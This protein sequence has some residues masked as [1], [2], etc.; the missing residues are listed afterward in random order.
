M[1][2]V[3]YVDDSTLEDVLTAEFAD[4]SMAGAAEGSDPPLLPLHAANVSEIAMSN[5]KASLRSFMWCRNPIGRGELVAGYGLDCRE[6][7]HVEVRE[8]DLGQS[9]QVAAVP[10]I[11][12]VCIIR[13]IE[14]VAAAAGIGEIDAVRLHGVGD[15]RRLRTPPGGAERCL[16]A[17]MRAVRQLI[18]TAAVE[19]E[20]IRIACRT[21]EAVFSY[22]VRDRS[23]I[24][25]VIDR[26]GLIIFPLHHAGEE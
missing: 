1:I 22:R 5:T 8:F 12:A 3:V 25:G 19:R 26:T 2:V 16:Q 9:G 24:Q 23:P 15:H 14:R 10:R 13:E 18:R 17:Q 4:G 11:R 7:Q 6:C 21:H 20:L